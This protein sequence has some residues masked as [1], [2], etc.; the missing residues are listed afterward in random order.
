MYIWIK[1]KAF[2]MNNE[3][4]SI[5]GERYLTRHQI[6][7]AFSVNIGTVSAWIGQGVIK[8]YRLG[9]RRIYFK[10]SELANALKPCEA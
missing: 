2:S 7:E 1:F 4:I 8:P 5:G 9:K 6:A 10:E 3:F